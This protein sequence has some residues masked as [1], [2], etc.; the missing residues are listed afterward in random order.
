MVNKNKVKGSTFER[1][2]ATMLEARIKDSEWKRIPASGAMGTALGEPLLTGDV[3]GKVDGF[4]AE[5]RGECKVGYNPSTN[6]EVKAFTLKKEWLDK[7]QKES[8]NSFCFPL[9]FGK[10][11][12]AKEG[13]K[14]FVVL[15]IN[16][17]AEIINR[18]VELSR[19]LEKL[20]G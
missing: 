8:K 19:Q 13:V 4:F 17:F 2:V 14:V 11:S 9:F 16:D 10:F 15:D 20:D 6:K 1:D 3:K 5:F 12:G 7:I 18:Y